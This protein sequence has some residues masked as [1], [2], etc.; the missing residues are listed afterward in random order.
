MAATQRFGTRQLFQLLEETLFES[1]DHKNLVG[2]LTSK[3][4]EMEFFTT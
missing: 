3:F 2:N 4:S 1:M